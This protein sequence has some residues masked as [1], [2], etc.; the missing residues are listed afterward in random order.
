MAKKPAAREPSRKDERDTEDLR[1]KVMAILT[2]AG[3]KIIGQRESR[4]F[5]GDI[6]ASR[7][8]IGRERRYAIEC[9]LKIDGPIVKEYF[10]QFQNWL[11]QSKEPFTDFDEFWLVGYEY[12]DKPMRKNPGN[13]R[14]FRALDLPE[15]QALFARPHI[16]MEG[17]GSMT[18]DAT[19]VPLAAASLEIGKSVPPIS[20]RDNLD[21]AE[22]LAKAASATIKRAIDELKSRRLN[23]PDWQAE[24]DFLEL[25]FSTFDQ[26]ADAISDA[27]RAATPE[28][29]EQKLERAE[30]LASSLTKACRDFAQ[31]NYKQVVN[32]TGYSAFAILGT[33]F[34]TQL[35]PLSATDALAAQLVLLGIAGGKRK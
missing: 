13:N 8:E 25:L 22:R 27:R 18:A 7:T 4:Q 34:F 19:V 16:Q 23:E 31:R 9:V 20:F 30:T 29:R 12:D 11:R 35:F 33:L 15:L 6:L 3:W 1:R 32:Y 26:I 2:G 24:I 10:S 14:H 21:R 17:T 5:G 28:D